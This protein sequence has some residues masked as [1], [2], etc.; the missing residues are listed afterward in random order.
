LCSFLSVQLT[1]PVRAGLFSSLV[2]LYVRTVRGLFTVHGLS[3]ES[4]FGLTCDEGM[5]MHSKHLPF[6]KLKTICCQ[7]GG[8]WIPVTTAWYVLQ[9]WRVAV[10]ILN[11]QSQTADNGSS[12]SLSVGLTIPHRR[13]DIMFWNVTQGLGLG[14]ILWH[15]LGNGKW[16]S[17][18][19]RM[20]WAGHVA[21]MGHEKFVP[22]EWILR[23]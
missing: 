9:I 12:S 22:L 23:K 19:K 5:I 8:V 18:S 20:R 16:I 7:T 11:K 2:L 17:Y 6:A 3:T 14:R 13:K 10:N 1:T 21:L 15:G 4:L